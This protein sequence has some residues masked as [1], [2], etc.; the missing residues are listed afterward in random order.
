M[1]PSR[2]LLVFLLSAA[3]SIPSLAKMPRHVPAWEIASIAYSTWYKRPSGE[4][5][6]VLES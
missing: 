5:I 3:R 4:N 1:T 2:S 6:V